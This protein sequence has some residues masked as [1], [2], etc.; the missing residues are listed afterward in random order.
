MLNF[1]IIRN[2]RFYP[3]KHELS[4]HIKESTNKYLKH[5]YDGL[6]IIMPENIKL[7]NISILLVVVSLCSFLVGYKIKQITI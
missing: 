4:T 7:P 1:G 6:H 3:I 2:K 5:Y